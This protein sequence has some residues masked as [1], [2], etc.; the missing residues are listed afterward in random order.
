MEL[1]R[2]MLFAI[3]AGDGWFTGTDKLNLQGRAEDVV[4][5]HLSILEDAGILKQENVTI[6]QGVGLRSAKISDRPGP[7]RMTWAGHDFLDTVRDPEVWKRTKDGASKVGGW[8]F[9]FLKDIA[10]AY[11][12]QVAKERLGLDL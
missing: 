1:V 5:Y 2:E 8:S 10:I 12:K 7:F 4:K 3:E 11:G 9:E 6:Y